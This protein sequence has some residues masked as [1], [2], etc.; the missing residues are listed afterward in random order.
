MAQKFTLDK[1]NQI[2]HKVKLAITCHDHANALAAERLHDLISNLRLYELPCAMLIS[3]FH[4]N[5]NACMQMQDVLSAGEGDEDEGEDEEN[6]EYDSEE[7]GTEESGNEDDDGDDED[8]MSE[9]S[10]AG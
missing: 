4:S 10:A 1:A 6:D 3:C 5:S 2:Q 9:T 8:A 7:S